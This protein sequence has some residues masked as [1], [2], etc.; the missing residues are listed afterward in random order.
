MVR[1]GTMIGLYLQKDLIPNIDKCIKENQDVYKSRNSF[2]N[3][4]VSRELRRLGYLP[5]ISE[6]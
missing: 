3:G 2:V 4:A 1:Y 5:K 6:E